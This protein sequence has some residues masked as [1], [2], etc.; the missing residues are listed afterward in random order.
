MHEVRMAGRMMT[1]REVDIF[2]ECGD[3]EFSGSLGGDVD[4]EGDISEE[5]VDEDEEKGSANH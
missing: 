1:N 2:E 5:D 3:R 4:K